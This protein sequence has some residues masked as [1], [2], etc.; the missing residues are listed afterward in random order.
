MKSSK[1]ISIVLDDIKIKNKKIENYLSKSDVVIDLARP[2]YRNIFNFSSKKVK[3]ICNNSDKPIYIDGD[4]F[5]V[6]Y[7]EAGNNFY[8]MLE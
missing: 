5:A 2:F 3:K 6:K 7:F 4:S 8:C 1:V